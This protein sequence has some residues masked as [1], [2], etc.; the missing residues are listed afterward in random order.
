MDQS[1]AIALES[2]HAGLD[3]MIEEETRRPH[4]DE[5]LLHQLKKE[6]LRIKDALALH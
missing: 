1:H 4:P 3:R 6:K 5:T 2:K